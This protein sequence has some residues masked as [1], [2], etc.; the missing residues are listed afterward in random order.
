MSKKECLSADWLVRGIEDGRAGAPLSRLDRHAK[1]CGKVSVVPDASLYAE[2]HA[3][4]LESYCVPEV[5]LYEGSNDRRYYG[6]CPTDVEPAFL[7]SYIDGLEIHV[8]KLENQ[9]ANNQSRLT[10][11][12]IRQSGLGVH[13]DKKLLSDIASLQSDISANASKRLQIRQRIARLRLS[14]N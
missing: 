7:A 12:R 14:L 1:A 11:L 4:G 3:Q 9:A 8:L 10:S 13:A 2:G 5:G 6:V